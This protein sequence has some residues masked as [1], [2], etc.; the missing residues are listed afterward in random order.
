MAQEATGSG[1]VEKKDPAVTEPATAPEMTDEQRSDL[2]GCRLPTHH[3]IEHLRGKAL[4]EGQ[5]VGEGGN[6]FLERR[7][8]IGHQSW[9]LGK[10]YSFFLS[11]AS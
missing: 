7:G 1:K 3:N 11:F 5:A 8:G 2:S 4:A 6:R 9:W 10:R